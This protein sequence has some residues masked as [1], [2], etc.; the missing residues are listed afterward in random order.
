MRR[1]LLR[2]T[3]GVAPLLGLAVGGLLTFIY[4]GVYDVRQRGSTRRRCI[5]RS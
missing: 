5:G 2:L 1:W 3:V 4:S